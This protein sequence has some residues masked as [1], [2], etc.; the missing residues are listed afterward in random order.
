MHLQLR[1]VINSNSIKPTLSMYIPQCNLTNLLKRPNPTCPRPFNK[2][3]PCSNWLRWVS[4]RKHLV[5]KPYILHRERSFPNIPNR[6]A[7]R[8]TSRGAPKEALIQHPLERHIR[9]MP[10][11][12]WAK[13]WRDKCHLRTLHR[14]CCRP[15]SRINLLPQ[16]RVINRTYLPPYPRINIIRRWH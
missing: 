4:E 2:K 16:R 14:P 7:R 8:R 10:V 15:H 3:T 6:R 5:L 11:I 13:T 9:I 12:N 1:C